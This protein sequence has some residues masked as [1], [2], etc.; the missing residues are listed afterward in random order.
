MKHFL[1]L[2]LS[3]LL[4]CT[5]GQSSFALDQAVQ[6]LPFEKKL[7]LAKAGDAEARMAVGLA[8][9]TGQ[10][11]KESAADA[12]KWYREAALAGNVDAQFRLAKLVR[13]GAPGL[14][15]DKTTALALLLNAAKKGHAPS[16]NLYGMMVQNGDGTAKDE[17]SAVE[18]YK[19]SADQGLAEAQNNLGVMLL[20]GKGTERNLDEAF[21]MFSKAA[22]GNDTFAM[23]NL[24]GMY[25]KGWG[26]PLNLGIAKG[27]YKT[28]SDL[29]NEAAK[30]NFDR[31]N[32]PQA[33]GSTTP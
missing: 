5:A 25:E 26:V 12:A 11:I 9:E 2:V 33:A 23:N 27:L 1:V 30:K 10:G 21:K 3:L 32:A 24:G 14:K 31:L 18:W 20:L 28:A 15:V 7:Q 4:A 13:K 17:K 29:G 8:F 19:R 6:D 22:S 16:E